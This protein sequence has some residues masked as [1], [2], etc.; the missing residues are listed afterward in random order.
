MPRMRTISCALGV[1]ACLIASRTAEADYSKAW[2]AAKDNLPAS[3][4]IIATIDVAA[5]YKS[6]LY[7]KALDAIK[8]IDRDIGE[9]HDLFKTACGWDPFSVIDGVV[10]GADPT[11]EVGIAY[12]QLTIDRTKASA[13]IE[14]ALKSMKKGSSKQITVKQDGIYTVASKGTGSRDSAYF[15]W[16]GTNV[17]AVSIKPDKKDMVDA[18]FGQKGFA[19]SSAASVAGKLDPKAVFAGAFV[20]DK[21][22]T[23]FPISKAY[24]NVTVA[25]G[26]ATGAFVLTGK[27]AGAAKKLADEIKEEMARDLKKDRTPPSIKKIMSGIGVAVAGAD[28]TIKGAAT[29][30]ELIDAFGEA[31]MKKKSK[32][33]SLPTRSQRWTRSR[34]RCA[35]A[36]RPTVRAP[37]RSTTA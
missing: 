16:V 34:S 28:I 29:E 31:F 10:I 36:R 9:I 18:W 22:D 20:P 14:S 19:K 24:G 17:V 32:E 3:T 5:I 1:V 37:T 27:D 12:V 26:K 25:G 13:C 15:P 2:A 21:I 23:W 8:G 33:R 35:S 30:K 6:N 7:G 4:T 11:K